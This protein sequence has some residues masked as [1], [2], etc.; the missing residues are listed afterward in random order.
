MKLDHLCDVDWTYDLL[1][2]VEGSAQ[3]DGRVYGQGHATLSGRL[4]GTAQWSNFPRIR[5]GFAWPNAS[6]VIHMSNGGEVLF[7]LGG[8]S[9]LQDGR[10]VHVMRFETAVLDHIWLNDVIAIGEGV[11]D[12]EHSRLSMRYY[13]CSV[14]LPIPDFAG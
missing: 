13:E 1:T 3:R 12:V 8:L 5:A 2:E 10:G 9:S 7:E 14:D 11:I 6:G 4:S